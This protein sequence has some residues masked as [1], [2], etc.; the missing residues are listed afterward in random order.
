MVV[1]LHKGFKISHL[2]GFLEFS[3]QSSDFL[4]ETTVSQVSKIVDWLILKLSWEH[5]NDVSFLCSGY[6]FLLSQ[7]FLLLLL[8]LAWKKIPPLKQL[9]TDVKAKP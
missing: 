8:K 2:C 6:T 4:I 9:L 1:Y 7:W 5:A 3:Q